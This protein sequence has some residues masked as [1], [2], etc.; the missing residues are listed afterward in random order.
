[1]SIAADAQ[2]LFSLLRGQP[3]GGDHASNLA[4]FYGPQAEHYDRFRERLL[5]GRRELY[6][7]LQLPPGARIAELGAGTGHNL[8]CLRDRVAELEQVWLV[9]LCTP[10]LDVARRRWSAHRNVNVVEG[11]ACTWQPDEPL[12]A[13][14]FSY[15][16]TMIPDW[17]AA[18]DNAIAMLKPGGRLA[19][20]DFTLSPD[21]GLLSRLF[22]RNWFRHDGVRL[23]P[24]HHR[25]LTER[26]PRHTLS[27]HR[28]P[29]PYLP[30]P[31]T[32]YYR[33]IAVR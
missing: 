19:V 32:S 6:A 3:S 28:A 2:V 1:M 22:W 24:A 20:V 14:V 5:H 31:R 27:F 10:L 11:D 21:Q 9:D 29:V 13:V 33:L 7:R 30:G 15:A 4:A 17:Q 16:L 12:D 18:I 23:D 25:Y 8:E 26:L